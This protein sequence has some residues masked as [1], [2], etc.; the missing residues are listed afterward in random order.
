MR[1]LQTLLRS[2]APAG[3]RW[4][5][6]EHARWAALRDVETLR[7]LLA[8]RR[9]L[10]AARRAQL[11]GDLASGHVAHSQG[12]HAAADAAAGSPALRPSRAPR[13]GTAGHGAPAAD[14]P[15]RVGAPSEPFGEQNERQVAARRP[16]RRSEAKVAERAAKFEGKRRRRAFFG[17]L[18]IIGAYIRRAEA[19][20]GNGDAPMSP[21]ATDSARLGSAEPPMANAVGAPEGSGGVQPPMPTGGKRSCA[22]RDST[23]AAAGSE[24]SSKRC[25]GNGGSAQPAAAVTV[26]GAPGSEPYFRQWLDEYGAERVQW[27]GCCGECGHAHVP[28][29]DVGHDPAR[30]AWVC[31]ECRAVRLCWS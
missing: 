10:A 14:R 4:T 7:L 15:P 22:R 30:R 9:L 19:T 16:R 6:E 3:A 8:D 20:G 12:S 2:P 23:S 31:E 29:W 13:D 17:A 11:V 1:G 21:A 26:G 25:A 24:T 5:I 28:V 27:Y 18:P